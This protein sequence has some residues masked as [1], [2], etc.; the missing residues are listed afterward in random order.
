MRHARK[1]PLNT[2]QKYYYPHIPFHKKPQAFGDRIGGNHVLWRHIQVLYNIDRQSPLRLAPTRTY[3]YIHLPLFSNMRVC[4]AT[5]VFSH[6]VSA[7][8]RNIINQ[9]DTFVRLLKHISMTMIR[10]YVGLRTEVGAVVTCR[11]L[12]GHDVISYHIRYKTPSITSV[13]SNC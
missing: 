4:L 3:K 11:R 1:C 6:S 7:G 12:Y 13:A 8:M 10:I 5:R 9:Y 2:K